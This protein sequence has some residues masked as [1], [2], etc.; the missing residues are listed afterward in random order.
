MKY[1]FYDTLNGD[2]YYYY[3]YYLLPA[4]GSHPVA[5][6]CYTYYM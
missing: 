3:Y 1:L 4:M 2:Y 6:V 5:A